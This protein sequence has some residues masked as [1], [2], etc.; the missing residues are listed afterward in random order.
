MMLQVRLDELRTELS[1]DRTISRRHEPTSPS[2]VDRV[3]RIVWGQWASSSAPTQTNRDAY[4]YAG[5]AF[6]PTLAGLRELIE[7]DLHEL[8]QS[9]ESAGAPW[10]P[11]RVPR[12]SPE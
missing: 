6:E 7:V 8:E 2:I 11:G 10:T 9:M 1:G 4:R 5:E 12:W 3:E